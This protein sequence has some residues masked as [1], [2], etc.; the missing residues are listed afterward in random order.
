M[1]NIVYMLVFIKRRIG[2]MPVFAPSNLSD[3]GEMDEK[4]FVTDVA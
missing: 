4:I 1:H 2:Y 3:A